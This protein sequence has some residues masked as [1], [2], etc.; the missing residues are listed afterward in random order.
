MATTSEV[1]IRSYQFS[2]FQQCRDLFAQG[3]ME[4]LPAPVMRTVYPGY[5]RKALM[6]GM[7]AMA[8]AWYKTL[9]IAVVYCTV[10][11]VLTAMLYIYIYLKTY[12][13]IN[14]VL[15]SD[16]S[17]IDKHYM[18]SDGTHMW[19]AEFSE[20]VIGM[21]GLYKTDSHKP[22]T[23]ELLR[24]SVSSSWRGKGIG[25]KLLRE[26]IYFAKQNGHQR[27]I[28]STASAQLTAAGLYAKA[29]FKIFSSIPHPA[30]PYI[31]NDLKWNSFELHL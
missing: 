8:A 29:G 10:C 31:L 1:K 26:L 20:K 24:M 15:M 14:D 27:I 22:G 23:V 19:V 18:K 25:K 5:L 11:V 7:V 13:F 12:E 4:A 9:W 17:D 21:V 6:F 16:L 28:L 2:D 30:S 3:M